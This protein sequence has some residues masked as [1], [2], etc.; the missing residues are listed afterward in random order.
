MAAARPVVV[1]DVGG[2]REAVVEGE[3]G[4]LVSAADHEKM[5]ACIISLLAEPERARAM[6]ER[7]Q[8]AAK[9]KFSA[10]TQLSKTEA[11]YKKL[12]DSAPNT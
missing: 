9:E 10:E 1:T 5:A 3:N 12:L 7:G 4:Y 2:A 11:L 8:L 6:G